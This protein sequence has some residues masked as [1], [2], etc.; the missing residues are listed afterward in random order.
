MESI[1]LLYFLL[2]VVTQ[3]TL[4]ASHGASDI[5][6]HNIVLGLKEGRLGGGRE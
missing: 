3:E 4:Y 5:K 6:I 1:F 2:L